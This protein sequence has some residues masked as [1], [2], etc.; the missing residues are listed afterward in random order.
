MKTKKALKQRDMNIALNS[1]MEINLNTRCAP[2][3]KKKLY[4]R[5]RIP[6]IDY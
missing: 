1:T 5:K 2:N 6:R 3:N 4:N